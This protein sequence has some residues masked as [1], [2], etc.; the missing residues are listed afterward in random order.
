MRL[1]IHDPARRLMSGWW[2]CT[3]VPSCVCVSLTS[4]SLFWLMHL[5]PLKLLLRPGPRAALCSL[6]DWLLHWWPATRRK[7]HTV[8]GL[9]SS[10]QQPQSTLIHTYI[11]SPT[12]ASHA[13]AVISLINGC[14]TMARFDHLLSTF[15]PWVYSTRSRINVDLS[16]SLQSPSKYVPLLAISCQIVMLPDNLDSLLFPVVSP[17]GSPSDLSVL[18]DE[19][20]SWTAVTHANQCANSHVCYHVECPVW[21]LVA[22]SYIWF[23]VEGVK[24]LNTF[25]KAQISSFRIRPVQNVT[26]RQQLIFKPIFW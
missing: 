22:L 20:P 9:P 13:S 11:C 12:P 24:H 26:R 18:C 7:K 4:L 8:Q 6:I 10:L 23:S 2:I 21:C 5:L 25:N 19:N 3:G 14:W 15:L 17:A 16:L 1:S